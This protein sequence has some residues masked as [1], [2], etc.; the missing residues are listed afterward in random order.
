MKKLT[1]DQIM[2]MQD[3]GIRD[4]FIRWSRGPKYD[5]RPSHDF[6]SG[7]THAG[8]SCVWIDYWEREIMVRRLG[9][10]GF[11]RINDPA[12]KGYIYRG[13]EIGKDSDGYSSIAVGSECIGEWVEE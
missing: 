7:R 13:T 2:E 8:L 6:V 10:Y 11:V 4:L 3:A 9:E 1:T 12:R 5:T